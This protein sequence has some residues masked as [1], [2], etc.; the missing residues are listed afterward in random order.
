MK[1]EV[2]TEEEIID[3]VKYHRVA[4]FGSPRWQDTPP[5]FTYSLGALGAANG[6][7]KTGTGELAP[8]LWQE[9]RKNDVADYCRN[10][11][12]V[13]YRLLQRGIKGELIDPNTGKF[14]K[15]PAPC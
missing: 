2:R 9:G 3:G 13:T 8:K 10:D 1:E 12:K 5:G 6:F 11:V 4:A 15:L 7:P 14:L